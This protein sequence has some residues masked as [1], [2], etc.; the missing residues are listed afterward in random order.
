MII[1]KLII[2]NNWQLIC[3]YISKLKWYLINCKKI[4][5]WTFLTCWESPL[6][7]K[8][9]EQLL[10]NYQNGSQIKNKFETSKELFLWFK[11]KF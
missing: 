8:I 4:I 10:L 2:K 3:Q 9:F 5:Q 1:I 11:L 7:L 6:G